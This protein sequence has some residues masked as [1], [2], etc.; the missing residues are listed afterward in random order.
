MANK[1]TEENHRNLGLMLWL[2][3]EETENGIYL[4]VK[5]ELS[6]LRAG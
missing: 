6:G 3:N 1:I 5:K 4:S 2:K